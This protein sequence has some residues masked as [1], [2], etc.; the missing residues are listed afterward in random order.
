[1]LRTDRLVLTPLEESDLQVVHEMYSSP[2]GWDHA[3]QGRHLSEARTVAIIERAVVGWRTAGLD[4]WLARDHDSGRFVGI[5]GAKFWR[6]TWDLGYRISHPL[7]GRGF[8][9]ELAAAALNAAEQKDPS[10]PVVA[11][12]V[13]SHAASKRVA[14]RIGLRDE[15]LS[16][17]PADGEVRR[18]FVRR[19]RLLG[20]DATAVGGR[21]AGHGAANGPEV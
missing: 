11:W 3:P 16:A 20:G 5:G 19:R 14:E 4:Y 12:I 18:T 7:W 2:M 17:D 10:L 8:A 13:D 1:M 6:G 21:I 15:G 9:T